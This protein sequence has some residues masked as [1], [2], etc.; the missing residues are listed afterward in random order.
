MGAIAPIRDPEA[1]NHL[2]ILQGRVP[3]EAEEFAPSLLESR[4]SRTCYVAQVN[5]FARQPLAPPDGMLLPPA[6]GG[7]RA[8]L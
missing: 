2:S 3:V 1:P 7:N 4:A 6:S 5:G 8:G